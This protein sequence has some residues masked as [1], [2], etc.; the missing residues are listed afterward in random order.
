MKTALNA[1][2]AD[3]SRQVKDIVETESARH[4]NLISELVSKLEKFKEEQKS[5]IDH[6][7]SQAVATES[8]QTNLNARLEALESKLDA[9][10]SLLQN[11]VVS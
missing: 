4:E 7:E 10:L 3:F 5:K 9:V 6:L 2:V 1:A 8:S 11:Q